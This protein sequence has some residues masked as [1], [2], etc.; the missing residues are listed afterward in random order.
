MSSELIIWPMIMVALATLWIYLPMSKVRV[1][2]VKSGKTK[3][4]AYR[5]NIGEPE[6]SLRYSNALRNQYESPVLFYAVCLAAF[7]TDN[8]NIGMILLGFAYAIIKI[9]HVTIHVTTNRLRH[10]R[11]IFALSY[12]VLGVMWLVLAVRLTG[13]I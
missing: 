2:S 6:D 9:V 13:L 1:A 5:L 3:S 4:S 7:V 8:A 12:A 11:S 10:R